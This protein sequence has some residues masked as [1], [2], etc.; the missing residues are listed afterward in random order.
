[1][2]RVTWTIDGNDRP[3]TRK[4]SNLDR[5]ANRTSSKLENLGGGGRTVVGGGRSG[6]FG[7]GGILA[8]GGLS[9][10]AGI[11]AIPVLAATAVAG[12]AKLGGQLETTRIQFATF[13]GSVEVGNQL[14]KDLKRFSDF[15]P[16]ENDKVRNAGRTLLSFGFKVEEVLPTLKTLGDISAGTGKDLRELAVIFGQ[17]RGAGR[18]MGQDLLQLI[19]A[20]FNPLQIMSEKTGKSQGELRKEMERG[21]ISFEQVKEAFQIATSEGGLFNNLTEKLSTTFQGK[22]STA[23]GKGKSILSAIGERILPPINALLDVFI[24]LINQAGAANLDPIVEPFRQIWSILS[25]IMAPMESLFDSILDSVGLL[26]K[27]LNVFQVLI[28]TIALSIRALTFPIR[29]A[30][31]GLNLVIKSGQAIAEVF[32]GVADIIGGAF[33]FNPGQVALGLKQV[34]ESGKTV[35]DNF[36]KGFTSFLVDDATKTQKILQTFGKANKDEDQSDAAALAAG[37]A[38]PGSAVTPNK[39]S[40]SRTSNRAS[41]SGGKGIKNFT[42][43]ID[44]LVENIVFESSEGFS[45]EQL[46]LA[47]QR[48]LTAAVN[49]VQ[50]QSSQ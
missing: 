7:G 2:P 25:E 18:L 12:L 49:D 26:V 15:T 50:R 36:A 14:L 20:G 46:Q 27:D 13:T 28:D 41:I 6:G 39:T 31:T 42:I 48:A 37:K 29:T 3:L 8:A 5:L 11:A 17:I 44:N 22:L 19:N 43:N 33:T 47:V 16:F 45:Q 9:R 24:S 10:F 21:L 1:M 35:V 38:G 34:L 30:L 40:G 32:R 4:L 23:L